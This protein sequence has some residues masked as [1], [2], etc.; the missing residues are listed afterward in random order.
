M[1]TNYQ[2]ALPDLTFH[3]HCQLSREL[4]ILQCHICHLVECQFQHF[5]IYQS[6]YDQ[7]QP[8]DNTHHLE[9][10]H[11]DHHG[12]QPECS[13]YHNHSWNDMEHDQFHYPHDPEQL[14]YHHLQ[15]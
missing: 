9:H 4:N 2:L 12:H 8:C 6:L 11:Y 5:Q 7:Y 13:F 3:S 10:L 15:L 1:E 14:L